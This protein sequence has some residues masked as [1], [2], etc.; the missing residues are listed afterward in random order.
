MELGLSESN[1][2]A[3]WCSEMVCGAGGAELQLRLEGRGGRAKAR[4]EVETQSE[5]GK[6]ASHA[7]GIAIDHALSLEICFSEGL[8][9]ALAKGDTDGDPAAS[10][11]TLPPPSPNPVPHPIS[12]WSL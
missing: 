11:H 6:K 8:H 3:R 10:T 12:L 5:R 7:A 1:S 9:V 4:G 2:Q